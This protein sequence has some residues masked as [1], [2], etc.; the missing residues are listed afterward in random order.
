MTKES[1]DKT[2]ALILAAGNSSR[3]GFPKQSVQFKGIPLLEHAVLVAKEAGCSP[4]FVVSG[5]NSSGDKEIL[6]ETEAVIIQN[7][8][9]EKGIGSSIKSG[10]NYILK[11]HPETPYLILMVCDQ[12]SVSAKHIMDLINIARN[13]NA[14]IAGS[15][16]AGTVGTPSLFKSSCFSKLADLKDDEG[17]KKILLNAGPSATFIKLEKGEFDVDTPQDIENL[18]KL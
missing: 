9:W 14:E 11:H 7:N 16:Y 3:L 1:Q 15:E 4:V 5:A 2:A 10:L 13:K 12:P 6:E 17:A 18:K 8:D